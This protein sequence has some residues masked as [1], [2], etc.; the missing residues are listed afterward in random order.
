MEKRNKPKTKPSPTATQPAGP[1]FFP[2]LTPRLAQQCRSPGLPRATRPARFPS[3]RGLPR[4]AHSSACP[5]AAPPLALDLSSP[6]RAPR[7]RGAQPRQRPESQAHSP[8]PPL[9]ACAPPRHAGPTR[10]SPFPPSLSP[11]QRN[12]CRYHRRVRRDLIPLRPATIP[13]GPCLLTTRAAAPRPYLA[14][15]SPA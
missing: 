6:S 8:A 1:F 12:G 7:P 14:T 9:V 10:Q 5:L 15:N 3:P 4:T 13:V 11:P 2:S